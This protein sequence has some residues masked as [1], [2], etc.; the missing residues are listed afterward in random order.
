MDLALQR[1]LE[2]DKRS[3]LTYPPGPTEKFV[4]YVA[5]MLVDVALL[6]L[7][8]GLAYRLMTPS[9]GGPHQRRRRWFWVLLQTVALVAVPLGVLEYSARLFVGTQVQ[10]NYIPDPIYLWRFRPDADLAVPIPHESGGRRWMT[11]MKIHTNALGLRDRDYPAEKAPGEFRVVCLGDSA[12]F[13]QGVEMDETYARVLGR[14]LARRY[15]GHTFTVINAGIP[16]Y[17]ILQG[18]YFFTEQLEARYHPDLVVVNEF[19]EFSDR[20]LGEF[21]TNVP[22]SRFE[23]AVKSALWQSMLYLTLRKELARFSTPLAMTGQD[24]FDSTRPILTLDEMGS[25]VEDFARFLHDHHEKA[26]FALWRNPGML[27]PIYQKALGTVGDPSIVLAD[28]HERLLSEQNAK[29]FW[30]PDDPTH[31]PGREGHEMMAEALLDTIAENKL[32]P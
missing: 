28:Y 22:R 2:F 4:Y 24:T 1:L 32:G 14:L 10:R 26:V 6:A 30:L 16:G 19:N 25:L 7:L 21:I 27:M 31:H 5:T 29:R 12:T 18:Y 17:S 15:P 3:S 9:E 8:L 20:Q 23:R 11:E 13:G